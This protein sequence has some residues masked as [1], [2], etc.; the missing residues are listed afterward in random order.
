MVIIGNPTAGKETLAPKPSALGKV[1]SGEIAWTLV[2]HCS[3]VS[4][5]WVGGVAAPSTNASR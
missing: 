3:I 1:G 5:S 2:R 4:L